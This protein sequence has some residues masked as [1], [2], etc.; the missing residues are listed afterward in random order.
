M[1]DSVNNIGGKRI[2][3]NLPGM[4]YPRRKADRLR[5]HIIFILAPHPIYIHS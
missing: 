3:F 5:D 1:F 2:Y 4:I